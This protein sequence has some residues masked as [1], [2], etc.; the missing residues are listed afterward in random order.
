[1]KSVGVKKEIDKLG[2]ICIPKEMRK[3]F[4]LEN[5]VELQITTEGILI[6][7]PEYILVKKE[8]I[9]KNDFIV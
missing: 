2:R 1:M 8:E 5:E 6:K 9:T 7:N 4:N 3:L